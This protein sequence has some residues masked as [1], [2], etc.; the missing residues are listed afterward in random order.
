MLESIYKKNYRRCIATIKLI[1]KRGAEMTNLT[2]VTGNYGKYISVK[3]HFEE[4]QIEIKFYKYDFE[5]PEVNDIEQISKK[6]ALDA[7]TILQSPC[8][9]TDTGFYIDHY[10]NSPG[11]P[12]AFAKR[13]GISTDVD[14]LLE[15]MKNV[16][17]RSCKFVDCLTF[18]DGK[19]FYTFYGESVGTLSSTKRGSSLKK[20]K[21]NLWY[22]FIPNSSNKT[23][24]E[25]TD[26]ERKNR[27]DG[28]TSATE[29]FANWYKNNYSDYNSRNAFIH[30]SLIIQ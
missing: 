1:E 6:K 20:A 8:F 9:V 19:D 7:Y 13:S 10:P 14:G 11:Y 17:N 24:A 12:G 18:Y 4:K 16:T 2:Y 28:H 5:E 21:S 15:T 27:N 22:V 29:L 3:E 26:E 23:L 25:M 30:S